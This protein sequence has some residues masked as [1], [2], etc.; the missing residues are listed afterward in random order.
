M[1]KWEKKKLE[2]IA[3]WSSGGTPKTSIN[4]YYGGEYPWI[5]IGDLNDNVVY[6][7]N[8][9]ITALGI[10]NSNAKIIPK[11][12]ILV[13]MY[14]SIGKL[15]ITGEQGM[16][17]NQ[18]IA[19]ATDLKGVTVNWLYYF[20]KF[21]KP[22]LIMKGRGG[23]QKNI[24]LTV[25]KSIDIYV[26]P[27]EI[28]NQIVEKI[29]SQSEKID[30]TIKDLENAKRKSELYRLQLLEYG[31]SGRLTRQIESD[32]TAEK[33]YKDIRDEKEKLIK[34][35][36]I[37]REKY[38]HIEEDEIP[39]EIPRNWEWCRLGD[40]SYSLGNKKPID[41]FSY[42][43]I[44]AV[45]N[46]VNRLSDCINVIK[47]EDAPSRARKI[48]QKGDVIYSTVRT[49]LKNICIIDREITP[50]PIASTAYAVLSSTT[51]TTNKYIFYFLLSTT[52]ETYSS[53]NSVGN[54]PPAIND[55]V[56]KNTPFPLPPLA[57]QERIVEMLEEKLSIIDN[58]IR[59]IDNMIDKCE[60]LKQS[61]LNQYFGGHKQLR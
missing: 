17:C 9:T 34:D 21:Y 3:K 22:N 28:Q 58:N 48:V 49:Y 50:E 53:S 18:A 56:F 38:K 12:S 52:M 20:F 61:I 27:L 14:G 29:E 11:D 43:D 59:L 7:T 13:G 26:P 4:E 33:L 30:T 47:A 60:L 31:I 57:E 1:E 2:D 36:K 35:K 51:L 6:N 45:D 40:I 55:G 8:K 54:S 5:I 15:G 23:A 10:E 25:I 37:K 24:S 32:G 42:I 39:F 46:T 19:F 16:T 41:D 44:G